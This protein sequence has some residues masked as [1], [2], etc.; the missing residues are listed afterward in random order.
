MAARKKK[1]KARK[2][3]GLKWGGGRRK[4][5][6]TGTHSQQ[7][8]LLTSTKIHNLKNG[9]WDHKHKRYDRPAFQRVVPYYLAIEHAHYKC[10]VSG[11]GWPVIGVGRE[12][13]DRYVFP[14]IV[15]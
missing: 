13:S 5:R 6:A 3:M 9:R 11:V 4:R 15:A 2:R 12:C 14:H 7:V 8:F 10:S 1:G